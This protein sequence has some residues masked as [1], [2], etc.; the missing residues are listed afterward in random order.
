M[1]VCKEYVRWLLKI[2]LGHGRKNFS[3]IAVLLGTLLIWMRCLV[4]RL[5]TFVVSDI[6]TQMYYWVVVGYPFDFQDHL[7]VYT[8]QQ[9]QNLVL[10]ETPEV[11]FRIKVVWG[12]LNLS[13]SGASLGYVNILSL[14]LDVRLIYKSPTSAHSVE[15]WGVYMSRTL[16]PS[17]I[18]PR[19]FEFGE[20][21][22]V[23]LFDLWL[24]S[25]G[26][27]L[28]I[29][30]G[31]WVTTTRIS[32]LIMLDQPETW[33]LTNTNSC[34]TILTFPDRAWQTHRPPMCQI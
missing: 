8:N 10:L 21:W 9:C 15:R 33:L 16:E 5:L 13:S 18:F 4:L 31:I 22:S 20:F 28:L 19:M 34:S 3:N 24:Y 17:K 30:R 23:L 12:L 25:N 6:N 2:A 32:S 14:N 29:F 26:L 11:V 27:H 1:F 7:Y